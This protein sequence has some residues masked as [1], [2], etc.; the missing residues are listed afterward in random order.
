M[1]GGMH[2]SMRYTSLPVE[3]SG[4]LTKNIFSKFLVLGIIA[5]RLVISRM[6]RYV[7]CHHTQ[8]GRWQ[9]TVACVA[10]FENHAYTVLVPVPNNVRAR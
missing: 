1:D 4:V 5:F 8:N 9:H 2:Q 10:L 7:L 3:D 6:I